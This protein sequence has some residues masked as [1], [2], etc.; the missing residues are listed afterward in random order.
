MVT[1]LEIFLA[2]CIKKQYHNP[3]ISVIILLHQ[4]IRSSEVQVYIV[5][6]EDR[7][8]GVSV[9]GVFASLEAAQEYLTGPNGSN[10]YLASESGE[11]VQG[12]N[13]YDLFHS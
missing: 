5:L 8:C 13:R 9:A 1:M 12:G 11:Q 2:R 10:C 4:M 6:E 3:K 7:G